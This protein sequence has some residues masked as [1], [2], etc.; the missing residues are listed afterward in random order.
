MQGVGSMGVSPA[1]REVFARQLEARY[2]IPPIDESGDHTYAS[3]EAAA[4]GRVHAAFLLGGNL[5]G[6]NPDRE[7]AS[8]ALRRI[9]FTVT[10][11]TKLNEGHIHGRGQMS[12]ILPALARDEES[13]ATSQESMFNY[14]RLSDGGTPNVLG[15]MRS[16][17]DIIATIAER[18]LPSE[19][20][21]W[22][23]LRSHSA[24]RKAIASVV[25]DTRR[26]PRSTTRG[27]SSRSAGACS[28]SLGSPL[29]TVERTSTRPGC[30]RSTSLAASCD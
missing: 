3:M 17:V 14:V 19:R 24:L 5:F 18:I 21:D 20:F 25:P 13:Q 28:A 8:M 23:E 6:S 27:P 30:L 2:G 16:E 9:R 11:S 26:S 10:V 4:D 29:T 22:S 1:L 15:E 7:W 12:L